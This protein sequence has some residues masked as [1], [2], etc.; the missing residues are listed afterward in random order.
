MTKNTLKLPLLLLAFIILIIPN[1]FAQDEEAVNIAGFRFL[2]Y[3]SDL[4]EGLLTQK[5]VVLVSVPPLEGTSLRGDWKDVAKQV[6][7]VLR[8]AGIDAV[9]YYNLEDVIS[10]ADAT[11]SFSESFKKRQIGQLILLSEIKLFINEK[12]QNRFVVVA[13]PF[14]QNS[15]LMSHGQPAWKAQSKQLDKTMEKLLK[16]SEKSKQ[17]KGNFLIIEHPEFLK[18]GNLIKGSRFPSF[19]PDLKLD[20]LAVPQFEEIE[21]PK[22]FPVNSAN[23][24]L[25]KQVKAEN[26]KV[27]EKNK[28]LAREMLEYPFNYGLVN[29]SKGEDN[30]KKAGYQ[31]VLMRLKT[32]GKEIK[33]LLGYDENDSDQYITL[34]SQNGKNTMRHIPAD[35][36]VYKYYI[37]HLHT[38]DVYL[39]NQWDADEDWKSAL[40][41]FIRNLKKE[42]KK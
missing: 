41:H 27:G 23:N 9:A 13:T 31:F 18:Y 20:N 37:K 19:S 14:N 12:E 30:I 5:S 8:K 21:I 1:S 36:T 39:G 6:H 7:P 28:A 33:K 15:D 2:D 35:A 10:G 24:R 22:G 4:P 11:S 17:K 32:S 29:Y 40:Q 25:T 38:G 3:S 26:K 42:V 16:A 34:V